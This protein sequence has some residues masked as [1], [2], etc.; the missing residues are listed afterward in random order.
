MIFCYKLGGAACEEQQIDV[1]FAAIART[2][3]ELHRKT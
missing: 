2:A 1:N 3:T